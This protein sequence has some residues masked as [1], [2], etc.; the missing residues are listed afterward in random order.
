MLP[1]VSSILMNLSAGMKNS[2]VNEFLRGGD[3]LM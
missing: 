1:S 3:Q 2:V